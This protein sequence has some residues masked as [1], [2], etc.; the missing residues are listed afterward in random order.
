MV[1]D[2]QFTAT[3]TLCL[4]IV[5]DASTDGELENYDGLAV[6]S[7]CDVEPISPNNET[8][9]DNPTE[10]MTTQLRSPMTMNLSFLVVVNQFFLI[11][12]LPKDKQLLC[13][14]PLFIVII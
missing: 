11:Q 10:E 1:N 5:Q 9:D 3:L 12:L 14:C 8:T 13:C 7:E 6:E 2:R 4:G